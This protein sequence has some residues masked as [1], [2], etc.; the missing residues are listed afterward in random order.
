[1]MP[2]SV[3]LHIDALELEGLDPATRYEVARGL[4]GELA[5]LLREEGVPPRLLAGAAAA[6]TLVLSGAVAPLDLGRSLARALYAGW[7]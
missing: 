2:P 5:R 7:R 1:M 6:P 3:R 4:E